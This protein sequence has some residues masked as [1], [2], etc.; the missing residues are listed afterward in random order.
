MLK[1]IVA[2]QTSANQ[3]H[4]HTFIIIYGATR[5]TRPTVCRDFVAPPVGQSALHNI[6]VTQSVCVVGPCVAA[7][8]VGL[9]K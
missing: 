1:G 3:Q 8:W 6:L 4:S 2:R 5:S 7:V 9:V